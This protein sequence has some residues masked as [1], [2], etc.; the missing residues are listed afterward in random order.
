MAGAIRAAWRALV[1]LAQG[2]RLR[3]YDWVTIIVG[4]AVVV[5]FSVV[6]VGQGGVASTVLIRSDEGD[7]VYPL[8][9]NVT[10]EIAGPIGVSIIEIA[11]GAVRFL[12][13]PCRDRICVAAGWLSDAGQWAAC[14]PNRV[15]VSVSG[16]TGAA[17]VDA[18][19][20]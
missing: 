12:D 8:D 13:S 10:L 16:D 4:I 14:L 17:E 9:S 11:D 20:F 19:T 18:S 2:V 6:A 7:F 5:A 3:P 1:D 15:F